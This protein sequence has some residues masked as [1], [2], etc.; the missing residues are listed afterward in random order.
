MDLEKYTTE[1]SKSVWDKAFF[2]DKIEGAKCIVDFGCADGALINFLA[3]LFP[4][5]TFFGYD[6]NINLLMK[7]KRDYKNVFFFHTSDEMK[8]VNIIQAL[9]SPDEIC[10][11]FSSVWH[12]LLS[13]NQESEA[14]VLCQSLLYARYIVIRDMFFTYDTTVTKVNHKTWAMAMGNVKIKYLEDFEEKFGSTE[15]IKNFI[16]FLLKYQWKDNG[17]EEEIKKDYFTLDPHYFPMM[18]SEYKEI[19]KSRYVLP[20]LRHKWEKLGI[21]CDRFRTHIQVIFERKNNV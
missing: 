10:V 13:S 8:M 3:P 17:W 19:F 21:D 4:E 14:L 5:I 20:Y 12:E 18:S 6:C 1:M 7:A 2:M 16:H 15:E 9:F 11:N